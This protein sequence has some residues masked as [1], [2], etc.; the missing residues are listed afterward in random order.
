MS[1]TS[2]TPEQLEAINQKGCNL[3]VAA[4]AGAGKTAVLVERIIRRITDPRNPVDIDRLLVVTFTNAAATEMRE[5][6]GEALWKEIERQPDDKHIKR[7]LT[8]LGKASITTVHSF[9]L[10]VIRRNFQSCNIDPDFRIADAAEASLMKLEALNEVFEEQYEDGGKTGAFYELLESYGGGNDDG[11]LMNLVLA[12]YNFV[13]SSPSPGEWLEEMAERFNSRVEDEDFALTPWGGILT[14]V[15]RMKAEGLVSRL[16][17]AMVLASDDPGLEKYLPVLEEDSN[18]L[19]GLLQCFHGDDTPI[20][21]D[22]FRYLS[23]Y[24]FSRMPNAGKNADKALKESIKSRRDEIKATIKGIKEGIFTNSSADILSDLRKLYPLMLTLTGLVSALEV[25]YSRKKSGKSVIDFN[26]MEHICLGI[27]S[28]KDEEGIIKPSPVALKYRDKFEEILVDEYQD[29]NLVQETIVRIISRDESAR[30]NIFM[31]GDVKQSIYRFRQARPD[32]FMEK[33]DRYAITSGGKDRKILLFKNFR[34]RKEVLHGVNYV[35]RQI[36]SRDAGELEYTEGESLRPGAI[37][38]EGDREKGSIGGAVEVTI[39]QTEEDELRSAGTE[40]GG[41]FNDSSTFAAEDADI[42]RS[43]D[44]D[45]PSDSREDEAELLSSMQCEARVVGGRILAMLGRD[46][47]GGQLVLDRGT[48]EYRPVEFKDIVILLRTTSKWSEVFTEELGMLGVPTYADS[49]SG[50]FKSPE[51]DVVLSLL[52]IIDNPLQDIP[53]LSVLRSPIVGMTTDELAEIRLT[54]RKSCYYD[55]MVAFAGREDYKGGDGSSKAVKF[56][57]DLSRW[58]K[59]AVYTSTDNLLWQLYTETGYL[60]IVGAMQMGEQR[61]ANL[62]IL[63]DRAQKFEATSYKGLFNFINFIQRLKSSSGDMGAAKLLGENE[64]VVRIMSIHKS[65]GL[66]FPVVILSGCGKKFNFQDMNSSILFHQEM[67]LGPD[68]VDAKGRFTYPSVAKLAIKEKLRLETLSEEMRILYV[69]MT[70]AKEKL[71]ITGTVKSVSSAVGKWTTSAAAKGNR[72]T[73]NDMLKGR[74]YLDWLGPALIRH[75]DGEAL[76]KFSMDEFEPESGEG[77]QILE[78]D[79]LWDIRIVERGDVADSGQHVEGGP[80]G[81]AEWF[82]ASG[83]MQVSIKHGEDEAGKEIASKAGNTVADRDKAAEF[84][85]IR[86]RLEWKYPYVGADRIPAKL[87]VTELKRLFDKGADDDITRIPAYKTSMVK[88]PAFLEGKKGLN[89][90]EVGTVMHFVMQHI[91][92]RKSDFKEQIEKMIGEELLT[93]QQGETVDVERISRFCLS[94]IGQRM[95]R[96]ETLNREVPFNLEIPVEEVYKDMSGEKLLL[97]G[98]IDCWF[99]EEDGVVLLD[100]KTDQLPEGGTDIL[101][102]RYRIQLEYYAR[103]LSKLTGKVVKE[104]LIYLFCNGETIKL[105]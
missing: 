105:I 62:R 100:Y 17:G 79:S 63:Y 61:Q 11:G 67:G 81:I 56:L 31:V 46:G 20:W 27:L 97:Q 77:V 30:P 44:P 89:A 85:D 60:S 96:A 42:D 41:D 78:D 72:L 93:R 1:K 74:R 66:E 86:S 38:P 87:S 18:R 103:A 57:K 65:K 14:N 40:S 55:A 64:N 71:I 15:A 16:E 90:A 84:N 92:L 47:E 37:F 104:K 2:W 29:S 88:K 102:E 45:D 25:T 7:Q 99:E 34:S 98:V 33:Y 23:S 70:R 6:I 19:D 82:E 32:L 10:E 59:T 21:D 13:Q 101:K 24:T 52:Q 49:G 50:F 83:A 5:R 26:D 3:L 35:F 36:M 80:T 39:I 8:L 68:V 75:R 94:D 48:G 22:I 53:L 91:D 58:R 43:V 12:L 69:G 51:V 76:R 28:R 95:I 9:C 54:D 4:A 73:A